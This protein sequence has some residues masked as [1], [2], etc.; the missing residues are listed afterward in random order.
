MAGLGFGIAWIGYSVM[1]YGITQVQGGNWGF[2][3]LLVPGRWT[4]AVAATPKDAGGGVTAANS[5]PAGSNGTVTTSPIA[6]KP[7]GAAVLTPTGKGGAP[8]D[9]VP[10]GSGE[11]QYLS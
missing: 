11:Q 9:I 10:G 4:A 3:D 7:G 8:N 5:L 6:T 2:L 1:Y